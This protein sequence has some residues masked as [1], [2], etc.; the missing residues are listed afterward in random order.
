[1]V[2]TAEG[3]A[4][5]W[6]LQVSGLRL[7]GAQGPGSWNPQFLETLSPKSETLGSELKP[8]KKSLI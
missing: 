4:R 5:V 8:S 6:N 7:T 1:M 2:R 3:S